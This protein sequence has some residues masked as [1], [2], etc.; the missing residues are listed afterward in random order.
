VPQV[1][2]E[3]WVVATRPA[4]QNG[5]GLSIAY[6]HLELTKLKVLFPV[7]ADTPAILPAWEN[8]VVLYGAGGKQGH[9]AH[10]I[11]HLL[12]FNCGDF[13]RFPGITVMSPH[14]V[15]TVTP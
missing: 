5:L 14:D 9:D 15:A 12:T 1:L 6:A 8:L 2:Y 7:L 13:Q 3:F 11:S 4:S 10:G